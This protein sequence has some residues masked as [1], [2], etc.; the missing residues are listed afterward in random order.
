M[1]NPPPHW[2]SLISFSATVA[3]ADADREAGRLISSLISDVASDYQM[4]VISNPIYC[5]I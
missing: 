5:D 4:T 2:A 3:A 1:P